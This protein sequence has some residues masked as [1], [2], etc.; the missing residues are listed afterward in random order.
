[1]THIARPNVL[2]AHEVI[3]LGQAN[4]APSEIVFAWRVEARHRGCLAAD[5]RASRLAASRRDPADDGGRLVGI[6]RAKR[7]VIEEEERARATDEDIVDAMVDQVGA[8]GLV[9]IEGEGD[10]ELGAD[11]I[12]G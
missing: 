11:A 3:A 4:D 8:D 5:E 12:N 1:M 10:L 9:A 7:E 2:A 6:H